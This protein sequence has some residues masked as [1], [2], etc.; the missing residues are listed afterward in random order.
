MQRREVKS[1]PTESQV[2]RDAASR[3]AKDAHA[4]KVAQTL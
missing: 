1:M 3:S 4:E 2:Y